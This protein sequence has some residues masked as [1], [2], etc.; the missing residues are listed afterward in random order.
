LNAHGVNYVRLT[1][2]R[3]AEPLLHESSVF[4]FEMAVEKLKWHK[5]LGI[6]KIQAGNRKKISEIHKLINS[7]WNKE[8]F[9]ELWKESIIVSIYMKDDERDYSNYRGISFSSTTYKLL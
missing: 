3:T 6:D 5:W 7:I 9:S 1:E 2:I 8:E 4:K